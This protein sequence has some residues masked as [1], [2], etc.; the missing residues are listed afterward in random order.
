MSLSATLKLDG[1]TVFAAIVVRSSAESYSPHY[2][3]AQKETYNWYKTV[4]GKIAIY[5]LLA[6][7]EKSSTLWLRSVK[8]LSPTHKKTSSKNTSN[9]QS[10]MLQTVEVMVQK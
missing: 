7:V 9:V 4:S 2:L 5:Q 3:A 1:F 10:K 8:T 6:V